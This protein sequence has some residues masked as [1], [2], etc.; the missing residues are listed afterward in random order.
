[1]HDASTGSES[2]HT[3]LDAH[4]KSHS[5]ALATVNSF[6]SKDHDQLLNFLNPLRAAGDVDRHADP[7]QEAQGNEQKH[8]V[9]RIC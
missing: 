4:S 3:D 2:N 6:S 1:M 5:K 7:G 9:S 8:S